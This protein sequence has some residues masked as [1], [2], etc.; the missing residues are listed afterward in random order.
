M[1]KAS[2]ELKAETRERVGKGS[3]R[4]L[5]RNGLIPAVIYGDKQAPVS[6]AISTKDVTQR[7]HAGGFLTTVAVIDVAG[8]KI[9]VLPKDYQLD[10]VR[11]F[12]MHVDFLR[13]SKNSTVTVEVPVHFINEE[14]APGIKEGGVLNIVRHAVELVVS[15]DDIPESLT[16]DLAGLKIGD[17][18]HI[19]NIKLPAGAAPTITD[20]DFTIATIAAPDVL[21]DEA[22]EEEG[23]KEE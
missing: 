6:I 22:T 14:K 1:S 10:P 5:R 7:I 2:Y 16:A 9:R 12:T 3:S 23:A 8:E 19:S 20:R 13:V 11:D 15:A 18:I 4:E 21:E 17:G